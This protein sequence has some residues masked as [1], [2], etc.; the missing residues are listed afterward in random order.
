[1]IRSE[2]LF[3]GVPP[4]STIIQIKDPKKFPAKSGYTPRPAK[5]F[6]EKENP[7][8]AGLTFWLLAKHTNQTALVL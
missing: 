3:N 5:L 4:S 8:E 7:A 1:M 2:K 6:T